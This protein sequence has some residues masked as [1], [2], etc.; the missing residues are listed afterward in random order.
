MPLNQGSCEITRGT[1][2]A[3]AKYHF[4]QTGFQGHNCDGRGNAC[5]P[6]LA[7]KTPG[8]VVVHDGAFAHPTRVA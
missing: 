8:F 7:P 6:S 3:W 2:S 4:S 5:R 1:F